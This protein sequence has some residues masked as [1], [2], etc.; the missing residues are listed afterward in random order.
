MKVIASI[1]VAQPIETFLSFLKDRAADPIHESNGDV[2][3]DF[4][5]RFLVVEMKRLENDKS[6]VQTEVEIPDDLVTKPLEAANRQ[7]D[8]YKLIIKKYVGAIGDLQT[9]CMGFLKTAGIDN[10]APV[11]VRDM[12]LAEINK[13]EVADLKP[14]DLFRTPAERVAVRNGNG[15]RST[16]VRKLFDDE[17]DIIRAQFLKLNGQ[18]HED[19]CLPI[20]NL[21][22]SEVAIFQVTGFISLLHTYAAMGRLQVNDFPAYENWMKTQRKIWAR[23]SS[24]KYQALRIKAAQ[25]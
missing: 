3:A 10:T 7:L 18:I 23:Y 6:L 16:M 15:H 2:I 13:V 21:L 4:I 22:G 5:D 17:R 19:A 9:D 20:K 11:I 24:P 14:E 25:A 8:T 1:P 12:K